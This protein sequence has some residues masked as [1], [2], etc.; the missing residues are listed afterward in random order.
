MN[1]PEFQTKQYYGN[2]VTKHNVEKRK[3]LK[4]FA[5]LTPHILGQ[6]NLELCR[7]VLHN[8]F[9]N[10]KPLSVLSLE[11]NDWNNLALNRAFTSLTSLH[12]VSE[13][14]LTF[15]SCSKISK[16]TMKILSNTVQ[17]FKTLTAFKFHLFL[18]WYRNECNWESCASYKKIK[19]LIA[20]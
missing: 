20:I 6:E 7:F 1:K 16:Q 2:E 10:M 8:S 4:K 13:L 15:L 18:L 9:S 17:K 3:N 19:S 14:S 11:F 12:S 5:F